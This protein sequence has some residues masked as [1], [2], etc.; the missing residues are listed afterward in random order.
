MICERAWVGRVCVLFALASLLPEA[1]AARTEIDAPTVA[2]DL[3]RLLRSWETQS[4]DLPLYRADGFEATVLIEGQERVLELSRFSLRSEDFRLLVETPDS[5]VFSPDENA[6]MLE[7]GAGLS[8]LALD[9]TGAPQVDADAGTRTDASLQL[10]PI[11]RD[12]RPS[13]LM[14]ASPGHCVRVNGAPAPPLSLLEVGDVLQLDDV[15]LHVSWFRAPQVGAPPPHLVGSPCALCRTPVEAQATVLVHECGQPLHLSPDE[16]GLQCAL[17][18]DDC[19]G[20]GR[21]VS[22][23]S[24]LAYRPSP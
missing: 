2:V 18:G 23:E 6:A 16:D 7:I 3:S 24:G 4:L 11:E 22:L 9:A 12:R 17:V 1:R 10:E 20:C 14:L 8:A 15:L 13:L 19:A 21:P 5:G